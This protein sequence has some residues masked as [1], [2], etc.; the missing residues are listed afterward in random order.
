MAS[1][2]QRMVGLYQRHARAWAADRVKVPFERGW[3]DRFRDL[4]PA[5]ATVLDIGCGC[6][7]PIARY[8]IEQGCDVVGIDSAPEMIAMCR[9]RFSDDIWHVAD[10]RSVALGRTFNGILA[11]DSFFHLSHD[12]QRLMFPLFRAH[13]APGAALMF[14]SGPSHGEAIGS[15]RGEPLYHASLDAAEY[16]ALLGSN[17]FDV[18]AHLVEDP[19]CNRHTGRLAQLRQPLSPT[20]PAL[21]RRRPRA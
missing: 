17:G 9:S 15:Y 16:R 20:T 19:D 14:T 11:W 1:E 10:M 3:L 13:A 18:V 8:L 2:A 4:L 6:G 12:D 5:P 21:P 7:E